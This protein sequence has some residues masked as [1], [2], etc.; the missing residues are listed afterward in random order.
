MGELLEWQERKAQAS[1]AERAEM[2]RR[3]REW[4]KQEAQGLTRR[5]AA[6]LAFGPRRGGEVPVVTVGERES[7]KRCR[8][9]VAEAREALRDALRALSKPEPDWQRASAF[10]DRACLL[11]TG[12]CSEAYERGG[13]P[14]GRG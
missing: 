12:V 6:A 2:E 4:A 14:D 9:L 11:V 1:K 3:E 5:V 8:Q 10:A 7:A 13:M